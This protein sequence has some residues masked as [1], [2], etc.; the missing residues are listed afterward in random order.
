MRGGS[1]I[2]VFSWGSGTPLSSFPGLSLPQKNTLIQEP[3]LQDKNQMY[4]RNFDS[5]V[6][7]GPEILTI[8]Y[9]RAAG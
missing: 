2:H 3:P 9:L 1:S 8:Q 5:E 4:I 7:P 6:F